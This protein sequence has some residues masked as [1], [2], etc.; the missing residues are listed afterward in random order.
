MDISALLDNL[1][2]PMGLPFY[3]L[4]FQVLM[5]VT[6]ALHIF[7][8][9]IVI[10][11]LAMAVWGRLTG[12]DYPVRLAKSLAKTA[13]ITTSIAVVLGVAPLLFVQVIYDPLWYSANLL[14]AW[15]SM[16]FLLLI[17]LGFLAAY[18]FYLWSD[19]KPGLSFPAGLF[20][21]ATILAAG[22]IIHML[23]AESLLPQ[24]WGEWF[25]AGDLLA[26][27]G[28]A[29]KAFDFGRFGHFI[30]PAFINVG[31]F[32]MLYSWYVAKRA[33]S[34]KTYLNWLAEL[35]ARLTRVALIVQAGF[36]LW[37][38]FAL[39]G[40]LNFLLNPGFHFGVTMAV[41]TIA[42]LFWSTAAPIRRAPVSVLASVFAILSM[43]ISRE[44]LRMAYVGQ[45]DYTV[46]DYPVQV[47]WGSTLLFLATFIAGLVVMFYP[48]LVAYK[49]GQG[50]EV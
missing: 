34:D 15:W 9:N 23:N 4:A 50:E 12:G 25:S 33:D 8:V 38:L 6:F 10:G 22:C 35:G 3:P 16:L 45:F 32:M 2:D 41:I 28:W 11:S 49:A 27:S 13:T 37:W 36:G 39:P 43:S 14:S 40:D 21:F 46:Y 18:C 17:T 7:V 42:I 29:F 31:I 20:S 19:K 47:D 30:V 24:F 26:T 44:A 1:R 48:L 5:V